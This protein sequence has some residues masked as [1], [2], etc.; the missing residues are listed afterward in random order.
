MNSY[1]ENAPYTYSFGPKGQHHLE[2]LREKQ[3]AGLCNVFKRHVNL[4]DDKSPPR[5]RV[6]S[7]GEPFTY[8]A[9]Y[10]FNAM[11][12]FCE[13]EDMPT[14]PGIEWVEQES[15]L[16]KKKLLLE[17]KSVSFKQIQWL[18]YIQATEG[19]DRQG[20][21]VQLEHGYHR[22]E[23]R[24]GG[25]LP[26]GY[27]YKNGCHY[28]YEFLG[29]YFH[30]GCCIPNERLREGW[31]E[32]QQ[33]T[34]SKHL[35]L[36]AQGNLRIIRECEWD[37]M[38][39]VI[40]KPSTTMGRILHD[41]TPDTLLK[42]IL[43]GE[44]FGFA[45]VDI[46]TPDDVIQDFE[47]FLFPPLFVRKEITDDMLCPYMKQRL[48]EENRKH[49]QVT[50]VQCF[51][52]NDHLLL[53][54]LIQ[55]YHKRGLKITRIKSFVQYVAARP[56]EHFVQTCYENRVEATKANDITRSNTIKN[57]ANNGYGKCSENVMKH[58]RTE[59][60]SD[61]DKVAKL[62]SKP[63]FVDYKELIDEENHLETWEITMRKK[64]VNDD[65]PVH[66]AVAILQHSKLL[67]LK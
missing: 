49:T 54:P 29:C 42:A 20:N 11:Y 16:Y 31:E 56:F 62:E 40:E 65:K 58:R 8:F 47:H 35:F 24:Y 43:D 25:Y 55:F 52:A 37:D 63:H 14:T 59:L 36:A 53:T 22:G 18:Y 15:G 51:H 38:V 10:D 60:I 41:D 66:L 45:V 4:Q 34:D 5:S 57:V 17:A 26:D 67:F 3:I 9:F 30:A 28:F 39:K 32:R 2:E 48:L 64:R 7:I 61:E 21:K 19:V 50:I 6:S 46:T 27:M 1:D 13:K 44:V 12:C 23:K 33:F